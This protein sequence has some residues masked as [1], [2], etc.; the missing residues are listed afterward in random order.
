MMVS[1]NTRSLYIAGSDPAHALR[2]Q[3]LHL[4]EGGPPVRGVEGIVEVHSQDIEVRVLNPLLNYLVDS[5]QEHQHQAD[6][7][8]GCLLPSQPA[9]ERTLWM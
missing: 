2:E 1:P 4:S 5:L 9:H 6:A 3:P 7:G 8:R